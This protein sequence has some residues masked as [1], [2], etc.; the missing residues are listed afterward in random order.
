MKKI[1]PFLFLACAACN[2][3]PDTDIS[4]EWIFVEPPSLQSRINRND[5]STPAFDVVFDING[6][7]VIYADLIL[8]GNPVDET[9]TMSHHGET[10]DITIEAQGFSLVMTGCKKVNAVILTRTITYTLPNGVTETY[11]GMT[12]GP[13]ND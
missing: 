8:N 12:I 3:E 2:D 9:A 5:T 1:I 13:Y 7:E 11:K 10:A 4:G 6:K